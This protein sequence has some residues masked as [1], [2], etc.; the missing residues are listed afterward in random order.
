[1]DCQSTSEY[2]P[3]LLNGSLEEGEKHEVLA[4]LGTCE[5]CRRE[6]RDAAF[7]WTA[8][9]THP[10][11]EVLLDYAE[12]RELAGFPRDLLERHLADCEVCANAVEAASGAVAET[13]PLP[14]PPPAS[15]RPK[16][17]SAR[18]WRVFAVAASIALFAVCGGWLWSRLVP[19]K[20][21]GDIHVV[22]LIAIDDRVRNAGGTAVEVP[23][24]GPMLI[25][26][27]PPADR[28]R[29]D[30]DTATYRLVGTAPDVGALFTVNDLALS[31]RGDFT[32]LLPSDSLANA[33]LDLRLESRQDGQWQPFAHY[34][35]RPSP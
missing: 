34:R 3:F 9:G 7:V 17:R 22:E 12:G 16:D 21:R 13:L 32:V 26:L 23:P 20:P 14:D 29:D 19:E 27:I 24:E 1:M 15:R 5:D 28:L 35:I 10:P 31:P 33:A 6:L 18:S 30:L 2:L 4:H 8:T 11:A 25:L